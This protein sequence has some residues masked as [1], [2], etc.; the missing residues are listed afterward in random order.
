MPALRKASAYSKK[1]ARPF[2]RK[3][4][5]KQKAYIKAVPGI[6]IAKFH[7]GNLKA[8]QEGKHSYVVRLIADERIQVRDNSLEACRMFVNKV[9]DRDALGQYYFSVKVYPHHV[10]REN[11][12]LAGAGADRLQKGMQQAFGRPIGLAAQLKK[13]KSVFS[14][15]VDENNIHIAKEALKLAP[16]RMPG[17]YIIE[18]HRVLQN[19]A[20]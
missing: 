14:V 6:K 18:I 3:S 20:L 11:K 4:R 12:M 17:Q 2:T 1:K 8:L 15:S 19:K 5:S 10:L 16:P 9:L 7:M 13:G